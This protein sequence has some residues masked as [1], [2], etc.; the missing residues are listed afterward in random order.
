MPNIKTFL[1]EY[2]QKIKNL[3]AREKRNFYYLKEYDSI[4]ILHKQIQN[5]LK[6]HKIP[7]NFIDEIEYLIDFEET[8]VLD[9]ITTVLDDYFQKE[10]KNQNMLI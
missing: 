7:Q 8:L 9:E 6:K 3:P 5:E 2:F 1:T 4:C 10:S